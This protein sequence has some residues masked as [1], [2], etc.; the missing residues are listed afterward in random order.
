MTFELTDLIFHKWTP[1]IWDEIFINLN[2][3]VWVNPQTISQNRAFAGIRFP[4]NTKANLVL[5]YLNQYHL[6][7][8]QNQNNN[9]IF[10]NFEF[11]TS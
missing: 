4:L 7:A 3:P 11:S 5:G 9:I 8:T 6:Q 1:I 2:N 10:I